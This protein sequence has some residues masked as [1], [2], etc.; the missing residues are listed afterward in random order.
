MLITFGV[1]MSGKCKV[2][3][4]EVFSDL[5]VICRDIYHVNRM[6]CRCACGTVVS[7]FRYNLVNGNSKSCGC[8]TNKTPKVTYV[9]SPEGYWYP[10]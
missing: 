4:G 3:S 6:V 8:R 2:V 5:T 7:V 10:K 9:E 1:A